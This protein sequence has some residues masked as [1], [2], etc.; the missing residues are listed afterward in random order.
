MVRAAGSSWLFLRLILANLAD[1]A[2]FFSSII[3]IR[4]VVL[5][6]VC[7]T[8]EP[9]SLTEFCEH[10]AT[11]ELSEIEAEEGPADA[12]DLRLSLRFVRILDHL[13]ALNLPPISS[14]PRLTRVKDRLRQVIMSKI[15][16]T[17]VGTIASIPQL[18]ECLNRHDLPPNECRMRPTDIQFLAEV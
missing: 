11:H 3:D 6:G 1:V 7:T 18:R 9:R 12:A 16:V 10:T 13:Y 17:V 2:C 8:I 4:G 5:S 14:G 15:D